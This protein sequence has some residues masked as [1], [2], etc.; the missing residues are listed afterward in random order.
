MSQKTLY[1][2][3]ISSYVFRAYYA[4]RALKTSQGIPTNATYGVVTMLLKLIRDKKPDHLI[5]AFDSPVPTHRKEMYPQYKANRE[6]PPEDL[7]VQFDHIKEFVGLWPLPSAEVPGYEADDIIA[8]LV[9]RYRRE[10][11]EIVIVSADKDLMQ[12]VGEGVTMYDSMKEK[13]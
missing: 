12:L 10:G 5:L 3:D 13:R 11:V 8:T 6:A 4:I 2:V 7:P 9:K 1:L